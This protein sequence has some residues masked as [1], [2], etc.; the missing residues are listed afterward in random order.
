MTTII[1]T[2]SLTRI[3]KALE[4][5]SAALLAALRHTPFLMFSSGSR[6]ILVPDEL[7]PPL[8]KAIDEAL[9]VLHFE[10]P[11]PSRQLP[12]KFVNRLRNFRKMLGEIR[13][14]PNGEALGKVF[15][16]MSGKTTDVWQKYLAYRD[17]ALGI[18]RALD[19]E[20]MPTSR[21]G[22]YNV[23]PVTSN[24][25][26]WNEEKWD[27]LEFVLKNSAQLLRS[28]GL[29]R[30]VGGAVLAYPSRVLPV[31]SGGVNALAMYR[32]TDDIMWLAVAG[33][34]KKVVRSF[35]HETGHRVYFR[36]IGNRGRA[37]WEAY[38]EGD[39][40]TP[41]VDN[42]INAW[43]AWLQSPGTD[44][45]NG[46]WLT[47]R[48][49]YLQKSG[50]E[51]LMMW[52]E[53]V[54]EKA[55]VAEKFDPYGIPKRGQVPG[56]DTIIEKRNQIKAFMTPVTAYSATS[57]AELFAEAF[58]HYIVDG[59]GRLHPKLRAELRSSVPMLKMAKSPLTLRPDYGTSDAAIPRGDEGPGP[60][61]YRVAARFLR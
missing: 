8:Q 56:L 50:Q 41:D 37:A 27:T 1:A 38:F 40:G 9:P 45:I 33:D 59:P 54:G 30:F 2:A 58:S 17:E 49:Q 6:K 51:D 23:Q 16:D 12:S 36:M 61:A 39:T 44:K 25:G 32:R 15:K 14:A 24:R 20:N 18:V 19:E 13:N 57:P 47:Y 35:I 55:G 10:F 46:R 3:E 48:M 52:T 4:A 31:S 60:S 11:D 43:E 5:V 34:P 53:I 28:H 7:V 22:D 29:D 42:V 26:E 21:I